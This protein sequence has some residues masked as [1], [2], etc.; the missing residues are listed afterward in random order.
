[1]RRRGT[2]KKPELPTSAWVK[3]LCLSPPSRRAV[4]HVR[5][6][7]AVYVAIP[8]NDSLERFQAKWRPVRVKKTRQ[9]KNPEPRFDS[10]ETEKALA[11]AMLARVADHVGMGCAPDVALRLGQA[12]EFL[13]DPQPRAIADHM[14]MAGELENAAL[15][16]GR[17]ELAPE[18]IEHIRRRRVGTQ[19]LEAMHHEIDRIV[20]DPFHRKLDHAG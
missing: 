13:D 2:E 10:I 9:I 5:R 3:I 20:T 14:R 7:S 16:I 11:R 17:L 1:M 12:N 18:H 19:V 15:L 8:L 4:R 6:S